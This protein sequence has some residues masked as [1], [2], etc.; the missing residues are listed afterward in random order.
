[1]Q[2]APL[3][4]SCLA[5]KIV[6][7]LHGP[8]C[9]HGEKTGVKWFPENWD[10]P[11]SSLAPGYIALPQDARRKWIQTPPPRPLILANVAA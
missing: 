4:P 9:S 7:T 11:V 10:P 1:M 2:A 6:A 3:C 8:T 5:E